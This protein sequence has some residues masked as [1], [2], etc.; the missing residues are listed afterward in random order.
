[1]VVRD[2]QLVEV[3]GYTQG[4]MARWM[5]WAQMVVTEVPNEFKADALARVDRLANGIVIE[6]DISGLQDWADEYGWA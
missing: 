2:S 6:A 5:H 1:M 3:V 4:D